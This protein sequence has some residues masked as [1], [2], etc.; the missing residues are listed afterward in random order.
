M[1]P[2]T[3]IPD[4]VTMHV[5]F[6]V[7]KRGERKEM[8]LPKAPRNR[9]GRTPRWSRRRLAPSA[10]SGCCPRASSPPSPNWPSV[11]PRGKMLEAAIIDGM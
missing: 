5:P 1:T 4:T 6:R 3:T 9:G 2:A 7:V 11:H 10:G 8:Q